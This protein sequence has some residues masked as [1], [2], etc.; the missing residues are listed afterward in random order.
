MPRPAARGARG[1]AA[2]VALSLLLLAM[3]TM[4][5]AAAAAAPSSSSPAPLR[6]A[7]R[8]TSAPVAPAL[9][10]SSNGDEGVVPLLN[11]LDAQVS[12]F[13]FSI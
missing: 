7:L 11:Y 8:R 6:I 2:A 10:G 12:F 4:G 5:G 3:A 13:S 1:A 9:G